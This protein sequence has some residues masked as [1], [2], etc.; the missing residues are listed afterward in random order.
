MFSRKLSLEPLEKSSKLCED[1]I[2]S[3]YRPSLTS[4]E[5]VLDL[6]GILTSQFYQNFYVRLIWVWIPTKDT[7]FYSDDPPVLKKRSSAYDSDS[8]DDLG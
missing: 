6:P 2:A 5:H 8:E 1:L 7:D 4:V 3:L